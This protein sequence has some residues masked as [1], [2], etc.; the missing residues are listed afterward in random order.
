MANIG[1]ANWLVVVVLSATL[2]H[3]LRAPA[4]DARQQPL[5]ADPARASARERRSVTPDQ[6]DVFPILLR[7]CAPC[8]G[9]RRQEG[10]LDLRNKASMLRGGKS[11][12]AIVLGNAAASLLVEKTRAGQM[13]PRERLVEVSVKPIEPAEI[14][15]LAQWIAAGAPETTAE[16]DVATTTP[17]P[18]VQDA[19]RDYWA[20][21]APQPVAIPRVR[22][23]AR[24]RNAID[25]FVQ[26]KLERHGRSLEPEA[27]AATLVRRAYF[28]LTG[29]PP[30]PAELQSYLDD[31][32]PDAFTKLI[33]RLL[34][35]P[36]YGER[37]GRH[38][39]DLAGYADS[40]GKREQD[41]P[42]PHAWRYRDYVI[43]SFDADK[44]YDRFLV[45][46]IAGDDLADFEHAAE[47]THDI[48][49]NL[50]AT[51]FLRMA[52]DAT[53]AN[54]TNYLPDR[55]E[56]IAD[57]MDVLGSAVMGLTLK[58]ARCHDHKFD[59]IPQRDY[60]RLLAVFR[61]ALDEYDWLK[62]D[63][64]PGLGPV[65]QDV[66]GGRL[67]PYVTSAER[68][69]WESH[70]SRLNGAIATLNAALEQR[71]Q[72]LATRIVDERLAQLPEV[73]RWDVR[74]MLA[75]PP[76][77]RDAV[78]RYLAE[79]FEPHLR[80]DREQLKS[81]DATFRVQ[82]DEAAAR[83][84]TLEGQRL[85][86]PRI[87]ALWDRG[88]PSPTYIYRRGDPMT[89]GAP[90]GPGVPSVLTDGRTPFVVRPPW[91]G[92][93]STGRRLAFAQ[94]L[95]R[96]DHP[97]TARVIVNRIWKHHF[98]RGIVT[99]LSNFG[100][101]GTK[102]THPEL[103]D[104]LTQEFLQQGWSLKR[105]HRLMMTSA[106]YRQRSAAADSAPMRDR[107]EPPHALPPVDSR[108]GLYLGMPLKRLDAESLYDTLLYV[109]GRL[110][111]TRFGPGDP[112]TARADGLV[113]PTGTDRGWRRLIYVRQARKQL[114][115]HLENFDF[116]SMNPNCSERT[117][118]TV[119]PQA[120]HLLNNG[121][122]RALAEH[123][124][125]R[126][127]RDVGGDPVRQIE[128]AYW[129]AM[130]RP[131]SDM[132]AAIGI[133]ALAELS[134][135]WSSQSGTTSDQAGSRALV[136]YCHTLLNSAAFLYVD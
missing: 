53:W 44:P 127:I 15:L 118:S 27:D 49:E 25:A 56:V 84:K 115:T 65:S 112:V 93:R 19:D 40:E 72:S 104:W 57:E 47:I 96:S 70:E 114:A 108:D 8:H 46:Q 54:I 117:D 77:K 103:L 63:V 22:D 2:G 107:G 99:T 29:L 37:W 130:S 106:T 43:R 134:A 28:D 42:R 79:K 78:Q 98:G 83:V 120:L 48:Y 31:R 131:P 125:A 119:A 76:E 85:P 94:W 45:E 81:L 3:P 1:A 132:E 60:F 4:N 88:R 129:I 69:A 36:R 51:G 91:Q 61:G 18:L 133:A 58:C 111:Q 66:Q 116:P 13:P 92:A 24:L 123:F 101:A 68:R 80:I 74:A 9:L 20:F 90:V 11:G 128:R 97:L 23:A 10:G 102:P 109:A 39:L 6:H 73:L 87:Q 34:S 26:S 17:D 35:S 7:R 110:D 16:P 50:V 32:D 126:V 71:T 52:P 5:G 21:R 38:W 59:P 75:T 95:T 124:A 41:L 89:P 14:E 105:M 33:D 62:P 12:P 122:V 82:C 100:R 136:S 64:R 113:T 67:L 55:L 121:L 86:E 135:N 30:D